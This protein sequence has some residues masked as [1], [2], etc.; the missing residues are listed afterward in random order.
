MV[1]L[2][3]PIL[4]GVDTTHSILFA[5]LAALA[6]FLTAD[7]VVYPRY[8]GSIALVVDVIISAVVLLE[9]AYL[10]NF[11]V[12]VYAYVVT[13]ALLAGGEWYYHGYLGRMLFPGR[14]K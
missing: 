9:F 12:P 5:A 4:G 3:L 8:G 10:F 14:R 1:G 2:V 13:L 6:S 11:Q 7:L